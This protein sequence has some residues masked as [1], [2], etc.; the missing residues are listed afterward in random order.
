[1]ADKS[2]PTLLDLAHKAGVSRTTA[3]NA[4]NRPDQLSAALR[5]RVLDVAKDIGYP[6]PNPM[7]RMLRTGVAGAIGVIIP[8]EVIHALT[9]PALIVFLQGIAKVCDAKSSGLLLLSGDNP[10]IALRSVSQ[11][12]VDGFII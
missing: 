5:Q 3:S 9:D 7:A 10:E 8:D 2:A 1:M 11:A 12:A 4:F 6:G